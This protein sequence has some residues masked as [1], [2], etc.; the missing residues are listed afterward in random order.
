M[1]WVFGQRPY[2]FNCRAA[3]TEDYA[4]VPVSY[5][6]VDWCD[7]IICAKAHHKEKI[8]KN[9]YVAQR[10]IHVLDIDDH[11]NYRDP[12]LVKRIKSRYEALSK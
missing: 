3:G 10:K 12:E 6:L 9:F 5:A 4:L 11:Y 1:A 2:E 7:E 8:K